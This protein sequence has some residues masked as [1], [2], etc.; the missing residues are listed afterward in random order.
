MAGPGIRQWEMARALERKGHETAVLARRLEPGF[1]GTDISFVG[2]ASLRNL[3]SRIRR[4]DCVIQSGRPVPIL[5]SL[6]FRTT[7]IF[8]QYDP[9][10]FE[11]LERP[12]E[13]R[14]A[15]AGKF[16]LLLLWRARQRVVL[17][18]GDGFLVA[19]EKQKDLLIGQLAICGHAEKIDSI[20]VAPFGLPEAKPRR[21]RRL[22]RGERIRDSDFLLVWGGGIWDW[23]DPFTLLA[24]LSK[25]GSQRSDI[26]AYFPGL[27]PPSPDSQ[28]MAAVG[29]FLDEARRLGLLE[30]SVFVNA[31]WTPYEE[32]VDYLLE[33]D[34][35]ISLHKDSMET[36][37]AF[38]T[39]MLDY[40][41]AGLPVISSKG[42]GWAERIDAQGLGVTVACGDADGLAQAIL[43]LADDP[44]FR[45]SC[46]TNV[47]AA[48]EEFTW[49]SIVARLDLSPG[50]RGKK[51]GADEP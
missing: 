28:K 38:R 11:F 10:L 34:A 5:I 43:K 21:R 3:V 30:T 46:R 29:A 50:R 45:K 25:L 40:L 15:R 26:K 24:A 33:A 27:R 23:F 8:D 6:L 47:E 13:S 2:K 4:A 48:A 9:V 31:E 49:S 36:R 51:G 1:S 12:A 35:G 19:N 16:A 39:R 22:L 17:R 20:T 18:Y 37:F 44:G 14:R 41:W 7:L 42:D 32:R